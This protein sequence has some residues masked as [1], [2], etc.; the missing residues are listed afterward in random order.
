MNHVGVLATLVEEKMFPRIISGSSAGSIIAGLCCTRV[1][2]ELPQLIDDLSN[3]NWNVF[4]DSSK[5]ET[6]Y[7]HLAR[8]LKMGAINFHSLI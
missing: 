1:D 5:P 6:I 2:D 3:V 4:G 8:L 7:N